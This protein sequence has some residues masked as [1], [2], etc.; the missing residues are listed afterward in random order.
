MKA[1]KLRLANHQKAVHEGLHVD[2]ISAHKSLTK[3]LSALACLWKSLNH[4]RS[5]QVD[6]E[7][8]AVLRHMRILAPVLTTFGIQYA[9]DLS[10]V[11]KH[12]EFQARFE[13]TSSVS[14]AGLCGTMQ[15]FLIPNMRPIYAA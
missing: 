14:E 6:Q 1:L 2:M 5:S 12:G 3:R 10:I 13:T 15:A 8:G 11:R 4:W 9:D 7:L